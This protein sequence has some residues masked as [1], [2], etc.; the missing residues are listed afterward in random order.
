VVAVVTPLGQWSTL[1][2]CERPS[3]S[4]G[5]ARLGLRGRGTP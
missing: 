2:P 1:A 4:E 5:A 3:A